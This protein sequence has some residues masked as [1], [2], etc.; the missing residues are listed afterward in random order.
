LWLP[1]VCVLRAVRS[2]MGADEG[3]SD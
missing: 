1:P 2:P 3:H